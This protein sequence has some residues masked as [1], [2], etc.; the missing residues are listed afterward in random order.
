MTDEYKHIWGQGIIDPQNKDLASLKLNTCLKSIKANHAQTE[1]RVLEVGCGAGR[2][3]RSLRRQLPQLEY[4]GCDLDETSIRMAKA[5]Q[6]G[7]HYRM[8]DAVSLP[9]EADQ[10]DIVLLF[11]ILEH[12][13]DTDQF[14][15]ELQRV[16]KNGA[17]LHM[18]VPCEGEPFT[19]YWLL[20]KL[21]IGHDL[22]KRHAGHV[23]RFTKKGVQ[24]V[25]AA[26]GFEIIQKSYSTYWI[27]QFIDFVYY[28]LQD[29]DLVR[30]KL[31][32]AHAA[33]DLQEDHP[34]LASNLLKALINTAFRISY[35]E[36]IVFKS[37]QCAQG[38]HLTFS[39]KQR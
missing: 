4:H 3:L 16:A 18:Y 30:G 21:K 12:V 39:N 26:H 1:G 7:I 37:G 25:V 22:T 13:E 10:F 8:A 28:L 9:Y 19:L 14:L 17:R 32:S 31:L 20:Y 2:F 35:Y 15:G 5:Y 38:L 33:K 23:Q 34:S 27:G 11:D 29:F 6:D 24:A 36:S